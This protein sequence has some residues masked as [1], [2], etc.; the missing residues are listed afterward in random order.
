MNITKWKKPI[1]KAIYCVIPTIWHS[2]KAKI[3]RQLKKKK[4]RGYQWL[5]DKEKWLGEAQRIFRAVKLD[6]LML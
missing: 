2:E 1:L 3:W 5:R 4:I 6:C